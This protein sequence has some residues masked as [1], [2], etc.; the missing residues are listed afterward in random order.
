MKQYNLL[1]VLIRYLILIVTGVPG[2]WL[3]YYVFTPL[4]VYPVYLLLGLFFNAA[5]IGNSIII[6]EVPIEIVSS[7]VAGAAYYLLLILN[8]ST[9]QIKIKKRISMLLAAF[10]VFLL[11]NIF[12]IFF[13]SLLY[14]N[15]SAFFDIT[16]EI[17][18][19]FMS[20]IFVV[21]I[22]FAEVKIFKIKPIPF[23]SDLNSLYRFSKGH[24][25]K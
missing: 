16:H 18:W 8:L 1:S 11:V 10:L 21:L 14:L 23:Y 3:F 17:F 4:T 2:L 13:L 22:W 12:R 9:P 7:C 20:V 5:L 19:Y 25:S 6:Q 24:R 15:G